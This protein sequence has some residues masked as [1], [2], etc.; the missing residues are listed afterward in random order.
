MSEQP[1]PLSPGESVMMDSEAVYPKTSRL[2]FGYNAVFGHVWLTNQ[3]IIFRGTIFGQMLIFPVSHVTHA[4]PTERQIKTSSVNLP[5]FAAF[6]NFSTLMVVAFDNGGR[7]Y[8]AVKDLAGWSEAIMRAKQEAQ[9]M[10][11]A[12]MPSAR[13]GVEAGVGRLLLWFGG[14]AA[15]ICVSFVCC[16][17]LTFAMPIILSALGSGN[18]Q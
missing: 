7:E 15:L 16:S 2:G 18:S 1:I 17:G 6:M 9:P 14:V 13:P 11:Y 12:A 3:R 5:G 10:D 8:F 4:A